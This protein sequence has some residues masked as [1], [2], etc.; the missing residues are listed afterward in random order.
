MPAPLEI[1]NFKLKLL[2][3]GRSNNRFTFNGTYEGT[4]VYGEERGFKSESLDYLLL[5][6]GYRILPYEQRKFFQWAPG[7]GSKLLNIMYGRS[8]YK[9]LMK[10]LVYNVNPFLALIEKSPFE[11]KYYPVPVI[12]GKE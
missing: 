9:E 8:S 1:S 10:D 6:N 11:G 4:Y 3:K 2:Y 7:Q 12:Y 5:P